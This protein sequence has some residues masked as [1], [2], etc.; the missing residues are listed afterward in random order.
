M[1]LFAFNIGESGTV[2]T[3]SGGGAPVNWLGNMHPIEVRGQ[4]GRGHG[5]AQVWPILAIL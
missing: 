3:L 5:A 1:G 4:R 2:L